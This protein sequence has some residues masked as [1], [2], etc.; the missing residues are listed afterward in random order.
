[1]EQDTSFVPLSTFNVTHLL[2]LVPVPENSAVSEWEMFAG[3]NAKFGTFEHIGERFYTKLYGHDDPIAVIVTEDVSGSY[4]GWIDQK[5]PDGPPEMIQSR[6]GFFDMQFT[7][8]PEA[9]VER[10]RGR[11][12]Q[13]RIEPSSGQVEGSGSDD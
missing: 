12:V 2:R 3:F 6:K 10:G 7:Y 9:E 5:S 8:G 1:M 13:L 11:I 4:W